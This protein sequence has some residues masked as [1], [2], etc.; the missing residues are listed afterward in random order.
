MRAPRGELTLTTLS[1][2]GQAVV[3]KSAPSMLRHACIRGAD[4]K[5]RRLTG[6]TPPPAPA[7]TALA[8]VPLGHEDT[9]ST[10]GREVYLVTLEYKFTCFFLL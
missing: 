7:Q 9:S 3:Q 2:F 8:G 10:S 5:R 4:G 1:I 6:K